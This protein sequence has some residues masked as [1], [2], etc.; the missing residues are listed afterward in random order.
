MKPGTDNPSPLLGEGQKDIFDYQCFAASIKWLLTEVFGI[1]RGPM[2]LMYR[3]F[4][5][6]CL[7]LESSRLAQ[8]WP[9]INRRSF[10]VVIIQKVQKLCINLLHW[11]EGAINIPLFYNQGQQRLRVTGVAPFHNY[12]SGKSIDSTLST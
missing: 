9:S 2:L 10:S 6:F 5:I 12:H 8:A 11:E 4:T 7:H 3:A 1:K